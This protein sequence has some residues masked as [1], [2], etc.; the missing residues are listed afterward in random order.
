MLFLPF[1]PCS[2]HHE[3][4]FSGWVVVAS[5]RTPQW[6]GWVTKN[7]RTCEEIGVNVGLQLCGQPKRRR[8]FG[9]DLAH[10]SSQAHG[11]GARMLA[12]RHNRGG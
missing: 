5:V 2:A 9:T 3:E 4:G 6:L 1:P 10:G 7:G 8:A 11:S 12:V